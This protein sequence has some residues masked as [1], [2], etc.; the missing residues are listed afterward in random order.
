MQWQFQKP[1]C[2]QGF[3]NLAGPR[4]IT[5]GLVVTDR[6][7]VIKSRLFQSHWRLLIEIEPMHSYPNFFVCGHLTDLFQL[8]LPAG[9]VE[10]SIDSVDS[11]LAAAGD[12]IS[13]IV[14][15]INGS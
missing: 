7:I 5:Y 1:R 12:Q 11:H 13:Q 3:V 8:L 9:S 6:R 10:P 2:V 4:A 15:D 14:C